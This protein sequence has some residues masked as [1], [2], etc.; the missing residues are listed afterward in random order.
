MRI[1]QPSVFFP[2]PAARH[3]LNG[4]NWTRVVLQCLW[5]CKDGEEFEVVG[6]AFQVKGAFANAAASAAPLDKGFTSALFCLRKCCFMLRGDVRWMT[7]KKR[8]AQKRVGG[9]VLVWDCPHTL[10]ASGHK[11][12]GRA[13]NSVI[14][15]RHLQPQGELCVSNPLPHLM[16]PC[17][18]SQLDSAGR[19]LGERR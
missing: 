9:S 4:S 14:Q 7:L 19:G 12:Q 1:A 16:P 10:I 6:N 5:R 2:R 8:C 13:S 17:A 3:W 11:E 15:D 18:V